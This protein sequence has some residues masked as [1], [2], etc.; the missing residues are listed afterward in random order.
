MVRFIDL[1][2]SSIGKKLFMG[3]SGLMLSGF[4]ILHLVGNLTLLMPDGWAF[5]YYAHTL[6]SFGYLTY[7]LELVLAGVFLLHFVYAIFVTYDNWVARG[8]K[9]RVVTNAKHTSRKTIAS[10]TMIYTGLLVMAFLIKHLIDLKYGS[11]YEIT[12]D[13][14][15]VRDLYRTTLEFFADPINVGLY[16]VIMILLGYH[17]SHGVWSAFQSLGIDGIKFTPAMIVIATIFAFIMAVGFI[18]IP[19]HIYFNGGAI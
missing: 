19:A 11:Y 2:F 6:Q 15:T 17:L 13:G 1:L 7:F 4:I 12:Y 8:V 18:Y 14:E 5:N 9:Y 16:T 3:I 10:S